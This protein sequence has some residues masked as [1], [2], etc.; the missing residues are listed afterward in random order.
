[1][2]DSKGVRDDSTI[3]Q[4]ATDSSGSL[5]AVVRI[6]HERS[7]ADI[8]ELLQSFINESDSQSWEAI[9]RKIDYM[10]TNLG[11]LLGHLDEETGFTS[12]VKAWLQ[13]GRKLLLHGGQSLFVDVG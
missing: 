11:V 9:K 10:Y 1:M 7:Y 4:M 13:D 3:G 12:Q 8:P 5:V 6:D 2:A